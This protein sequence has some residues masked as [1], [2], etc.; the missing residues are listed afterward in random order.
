M[1]EAKNTRRSTVR[2]S[3]DGR[4]FKNFR[5][6]QARER[7]LN[8]IKVLEYLREK[9][10]PF[11]PKVISHDESELLLVTS[12]CGKKVD[13]MGE[14]KKQSIFSELE[15]FGVRHDDPELRNITYRMSD[16]RF[17]VIDFEFATILDD[18]DH[19]PP[20]PFDPKSIDI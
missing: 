14:K 17:C 5:G 6:H 11:V 8:E 9:G 1:E 13:H 20:K 19:N 2:L 12:N 18:P 3:F 10:C 15:S 7:F 4:V 16:G